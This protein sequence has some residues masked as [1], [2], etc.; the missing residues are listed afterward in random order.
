ME[1]SAH[2]DTAELFGDTITLITGRGMGME[3][4][5]GRFP[6]PR[7]YLLPFHEVGPAVRDEKIGGA[8]ME[9]CEL[10]DRRG[11]L[12][13]HGEGSSS[14]VPKAAFFIYLEV[15]SRIFELEMPSSMDPTSILTICGRARKERASLLAMD[16]ARKEIQ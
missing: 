13:K 2:P 4:N 15:V 1:W 6:H 9:V 5:S 10:W 16:H 3:S 11:E 8:L 14:Y 12:G 7:G